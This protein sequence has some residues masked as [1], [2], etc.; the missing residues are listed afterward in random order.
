MAATTSRVVVV[1]GPPL[2]GPLA[3]ELAVRVHCILGRE[4]V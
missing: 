2:V 1:A 4:Q 3:L